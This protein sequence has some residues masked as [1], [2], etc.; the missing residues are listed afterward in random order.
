MEEMKKELE[1]LKAHLVALQEQLA[2]K[3][4]ERDDFQLDV[5]EYED[6]Y[7]QMLD[8]C[9][10]EMFGW[11]PSTILARIDPIQYNC[12]L[13]DYVDS[14]DVE[15]DETYKELLEEIEEI[16]QEIEETEEE[17][18]DL[19]NQIEEMEEEEEETEE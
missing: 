12:G 16:E 10:P 7:C 19:E 14:L 5:S 18:D 13:T 2:E 6:S 9:Y 15:E 11:T 1:V 17:I 8:D 3:E 4:K